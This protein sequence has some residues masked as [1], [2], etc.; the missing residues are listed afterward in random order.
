MQPLQEKG[1]P[2]VCC[3]LFVPCEKST[4]MVSTGSPT[5]RHDRIVYQADAPLFSWPPW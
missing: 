2:A 3:A 4:N 5:H 1:G